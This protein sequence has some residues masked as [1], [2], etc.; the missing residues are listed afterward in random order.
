MFAALRVALNDCRRCSFCSFDARHGVERKYKSALKRSRQLQWWSGHGLSG[1][2]CQPPR[3]PEQPPPAPRV[4][5]CRRKI[6]RGAA[7][8]R[9]QASYAIHRIHVHP[10]LAAV[11]RPTVNLS[12]MHE[13]ETFRARLVDE[14]YPAWKRSATVVTQATQCA[15]LVGR[16]SLHAESADLL[17]TCRCCSR[18]RSMQVSY[19][20]EAVRYAVD[21]E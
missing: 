8:T 18:I 14:S 6:S 9:R 13:S 1:R 12:A 16:A 4:M 20:I 7:V 21:D 3:P 2:R 5:L 15:Y 19:E 10:T 11:K 17:E